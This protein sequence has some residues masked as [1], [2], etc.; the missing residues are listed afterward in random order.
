MGYISRLTFVVKDKTLHGR[1]VCQA[2]IGYLNTL[3]LQF[4]GNVWLA[5][6]G[7]DVAWLYGSASLGREKLADDG[8][9]TEHHLD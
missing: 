9:T 8:T 2:D 1:L 4:G 7:N 3:L 6:D 5:N